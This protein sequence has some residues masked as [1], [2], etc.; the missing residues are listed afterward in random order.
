[1]IAILADAL[2][3][4][5]LLLGG[6]FV[7]T[8]G[9]GF[10]R[11]PDVYTRAHAASLTDMAGAAL[12]LVGLMAQAGPTLLTV[13][14][15]FILAFLWMTSP[16]STHALINAAFSAKVKPILAHD[17]TGAPPAPQEAPSSR[18]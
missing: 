6:G 1:M 11:M 4:A 17:L 3:W 7:I 5:C 2:S 10:L 18:S 16:V 9:I 12:M 15:V 8:G 14:L 13:K